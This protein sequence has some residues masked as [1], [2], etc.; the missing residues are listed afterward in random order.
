MRAAD[1][2]A[3]RSAFEHLSPESRYSRFLALMDTLSEAQLRYLTEVDHHDHEALVAYEGDTGRG[4]AVA[5][6]VRSE[7]DPAVAE[8]AVVVD[9]DWQGRGLGT[10]LCRLIA[11]RAR[12]EG[13]E[14]FEATLLAGNDRVLHL[15]DALGPSRVVDRDGPT[16]TVEVDL[17]ARDLGEHMRGVLRTVARGAAELAPPDADA[18]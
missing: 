6:F 13:V 15:L 3:I 14:R 17:P 11:D 8:A 10:V 4:I 5:R 2:G 7:R 18:G 16:I 1:K 9:D 12:D